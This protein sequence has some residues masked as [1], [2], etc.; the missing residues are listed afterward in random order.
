MSLDRARELTDINFWGAV[1]V[2]FEA[3]RSFREKNQK[4]YEGCSSKYRAWQRPPQ[5]RWSGSPIPQ[6]QMNWLCYLWHIL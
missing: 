5:S 6:K 1:M 2:S 4:G 3:V